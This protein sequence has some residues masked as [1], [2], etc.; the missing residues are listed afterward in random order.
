MLKVCRIPRT[1]THWSISPRN[2]S[3]NRSAIYGRF[4]TEAIGMISQR[5]CYSL[6]RI[7]ALHKRHTNG[8][9]K[10]I[11]KTRVLCASLK[12]QDF[13]STI[14][15]SVL[16]GKLSIVHVRCIVKQI[17]FTGSWEPLLIRVIWNSVICEVLVSGETTNNNISGCFFPCWLNN[18]QS[19]TRLSASWAEKWKHLGACRSCSDILLYVSCHVVWAS[20][21]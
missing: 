3:V 8:K 18:F 6:T 15:R 17:N 10:Y 7:L 14:N 4:S 9:H 12:P 20:C 1:I 11:L 21:C 2:N 13:Y 5:S 19:F 16:V